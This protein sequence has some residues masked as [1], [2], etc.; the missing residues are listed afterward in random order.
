MK[1]KIRTFTRKDIED[2]LDGKLAGKRLTQK[3]LVDSLFECL[4]EV[5]LEA[6]PIARVEIRDF[7]VF[8]IK[9]TRPKP[10]ARNMKTG[11]FMFVPG[12][13]KIHFKPGKILKEFLKEDFK[14]SADKN[15]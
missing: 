7:G 1:E 12:R 11:E 6:D 8:E 10:K 3:I 13:R 9:K 14:D 4:R 2:R 15:V 5:L